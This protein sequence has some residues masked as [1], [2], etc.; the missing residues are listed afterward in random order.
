MNDE[1]QE[2]TEQSPEEKAELAEWNDVEDLL[3][4][5]HGQ[6]YSLV[7]HR[8]KPQWCA[9]Y[10]DTWPLD[11]PISLGDIKEAFGGRRFQLKIHGPKGRLIRH[12]MVSIDAP[13]RRDGSLVQPDAVPTYADTPRNAKHDAGENTLF[14]MLEKSNDRTLGLF[15]KMLVT[16]SSSAD[17]TSPLAQ[18]SALV[19]AVSK[20]KEV[21]SMFG[22]DQDSTSSMIQG[23]M[24]LLEAKQKQQQQQPQQQRPRP[25]LPAPQIIRRPA[26]PAPGQA[27]QRNPAPAEQRQLAHVDE[28]LQ[29]D[30]VDDQ[31]DDLDDIDPVELLREMD[32]AAAGE[33]VA[34]YFNALSPEEAQQALS[35]FLGE[36][37]PLDTIH[38]MRGKSNDD[39]E[40]PTDEPDDQIAPP[41]SQ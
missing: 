26:P 37:V 22:A 3:G 29:A 36:N 2:K 20:M 4:E 32:P 30:D 13:P 34:A 33:H 23:F 21:S 19:E 15:E 41:I 6:G 18:I 39:P 7:I 17:Q 24:G 27:V 9:G 8:K 14:S 16:K 35:A 11:E 5:A 12:I 1:T 10:L 40:A 28:P 38:A 25:G 31:A